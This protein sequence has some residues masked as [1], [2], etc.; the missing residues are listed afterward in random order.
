MM[1][2]YVLVTAAYNEEKYIEETIRSVV[3]QSVTPLRWIISSDGSTDRTE[4]IVNAYVAG[5][6]FLR[7]CHISDEHPRNF[8]AQ[9]IAINRGLAHLR[10]L[11]YD[12]VGNLDAD[13]T[14]EPDYFARLLKKFDDD[15]KLGLGGGSVYE[16]S[17]DGKFGPRRGNS[18]IS[19]AHG[20]QLFRRE[21]FEAIGAHY[22]PLPYGGPDTYAEVTARMNG[23]RVKSFSDLPVFHHRA[24]TSAEGMLKG[25][26]RQGRMDYSL[27]ADPGFELLKLLRRVR[28]K[29]FLIGSMARCA[30]FIGSYL[31]RE[32][33]PVE[34]EFVCYLRREQRMRVRN[35]FRFGGKTATQRQDSSPYRDDTQSSS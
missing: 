8:A 14:L 22:T 16:R 25:S 21:C 12:Y 9:V 10:D 5:Y 34:N 20:C 17:G 15:P 29:P 2:S 31:L 28:S 23:W 13:I 6:S 4:D 26:F 32:E 27:G 18:A 1:T 19:V 3:A 7:L 24:T 30:G 35:V 33:R 11:P